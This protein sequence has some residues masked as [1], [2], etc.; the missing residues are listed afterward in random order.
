MNDVFWEYKAGQWI[1]TEGPMNAPQFK[2]EEIVDKIIEQ[3]GYIVSFRFGEQSFYDL[4]V[5]EHEEPQK[6]M[7]YTWLVEMNLGGLY[8]RY[9]YLKSFGDLFMF[10]K[11]CSG[12]IT[13]SHLGD[14]IQTYSPIAEYLTRDTKKIVQ[15]EEKARR[16]A[17]KR[18]YK[19]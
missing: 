5:Y 14:T 17:Y 3:L 6:V 16:A 10:L 12:M 2:E 7:G 1:E 9:V 8:I 18:R 4:V 13:A 15:E 19:Q 11:D